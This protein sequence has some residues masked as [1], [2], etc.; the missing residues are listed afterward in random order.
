MRI[1][2][3]EFIKQIN[4]LCGRNKVFCL[5]QFIVCF[6]I[7][8]VFVFYFSQQFRMGFFY[9]SYSGQYFGVVVGRII[10]LQF[11]FF[12]W[13][14]FRTFLQGAFFFVF[15]LIGLVF[16]YFFGFCLFLRRVV[17]CCSF[18]IRGLKFFSFFLVVFSRRR[19]VCVVFV[20]WFTFLMF[21]IQFRFVSQD[22]VFRSW[23]DIDGVSFFWSMFFSVFSL[24]FMVIRL[25]IGIIGEF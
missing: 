8:R 22:F 11:F 12:W 23:G 21:R 7:F 19:K 4:I 13:Y 6:Y 18:S 15:Y 3:L 24:G 25:Y 20:F 10:L 2:G 9:C 16:T 14:Q 17:V 5:W 1:R